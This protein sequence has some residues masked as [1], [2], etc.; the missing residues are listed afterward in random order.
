MGNG[1]SK[2]S[3]DNRKNRYTTQKGATTAATSQQDPSFKYNKPQID[4]DAQ[5]VSIHGTK[6]TDVATNAKPRGGSVQAT[7]ADKYMA[8]LAKRFPGSSGEQL[9]KKTKEG[10]F[11]SQSMIDTYNK[12]YYKPKTTTHDIKTQWS[13][14]I[15]FNIDPEKEP[16]VDFTPKVETGGHDPKDLAN[17]PINTKAGNMDEFLKGKGKIDT[18]REEESTDIGDEGFGSTD[19]D[20]KTRGIAN[21]DWGLA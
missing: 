21:K 13:T 3:K 19:T 15:D 2:L 18:F 1:G 20:L 12:K 16:G 6:T 9:A 14:D 4:T 11:I 10:S 8:G 7:D 17:N 5:T